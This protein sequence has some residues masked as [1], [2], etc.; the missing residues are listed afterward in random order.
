MILHFDPYSERY[1]QAEKEN[2]LYRISAMRT[3]TD[4][5]TTAVIEDIKNRS[6]IAYGLKL[7]G[8]KLSWA[9]K[10]QCENKDQALEA[11]FKTEVEKVNVMK[12]NR[13]IKHQR[14]R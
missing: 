7:N 12:K 11:L 9:Y 14:G 4:G 10:G 8:H 13:N 1:Y 2:M 6:Y 3:E 5:H